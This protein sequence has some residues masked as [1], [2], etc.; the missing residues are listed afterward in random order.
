[1]YADMP[2]HKKN[3]FGKFSESGRRD[4]G[5]G[6]FK[7]NTWRK[8]NIFGIYA[9]TSTAIQL[10]NSVISSEYILGKIGLE[11]RGITNGIQFQLKSFA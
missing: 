10:H 9:N 5:G 2:Q 6:T 4:Y 8:S 11:R 7:G 1:M 3:I